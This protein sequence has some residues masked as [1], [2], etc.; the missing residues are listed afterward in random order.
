[1]AKILVPTDFSSNSLNAARYAVQLY[2]TEGNEFIVL[3]SFMMPRGAAS[4]MWSIDDLLAKEAHEGVESFI[5]R[6]REEPALAN[7]QFTPAIEHG[8]LPNVVDRFAHDP[9]P[10]E[11]VVMGTQGATGLKEVLMG[12]NTADVIKRGGL[13]VLAVPQDANYR[14]PKRIILADDGGPVRKESIKV[15]VDVARWSHAEVMIVRVT[16]PERAG[17]EVG[18]SAYDVLLGAV[19]HSHHFISGEN[20]NTALHDLADQSDADLVVVLHRKRGLFEQ[21]FHRSTSTK[22]AMHTHIPMLVLQQ[23]AE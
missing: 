17:E 20:V 7:A 3:N 14:A 9:E 1:M 10:P 13:P 16:D 11:I 2:G 4:T 6:M 18:D 22:L 15:L 21:L 8:D 12:S 19:P 23:P 5:A